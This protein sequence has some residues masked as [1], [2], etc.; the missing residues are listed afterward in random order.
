MISGQ[1]ELIRSLR[2]VINERTSHEKALQEQVDYLTKK[3]LGSSCE[4]RADDISGQQH[5][6]DEA[7][8]KQDLSFVERRDRDPGAYPQ[9][10]SNP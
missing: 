7:E 1:T 10:E 3:L 5:L 9:E 4:K 2:L 8:V 6:F